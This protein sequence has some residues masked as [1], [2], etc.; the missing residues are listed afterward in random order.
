[1]SETHTMPHEIEDAPNA[2]KIPKAVLVARSFLGSD[3]PSP[4]DVKKL[5]HK[6][7]KSL[8]NAFRNSMTAS[9]KEKYAALSCHEA[10]REWLAQFIADPCIGKKSGFNTF[11]PYP[12]R[13]K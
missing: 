4:E 9:V 1:M 2:S 10:R 12:G 8:F 5:V 11:L 6:E 3:K 7:R 13:S